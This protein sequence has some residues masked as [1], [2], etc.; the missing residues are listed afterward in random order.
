MTIRRQPSQLLYMMLAYACV[1]VGGIG[2]V[3]PLLPTTPFLLVAAWA[4]T[5][6]SPRLR[7]W[8]YRHPRYGPSIRAWQ[9]HRAIPAGAKLT[10][11]LL[12][13]LS[14][15]TLWVLGIDGRILAGLTLF[16]MA[17]AT[18]ILSR[19]SLPATRTASAPTCRPSP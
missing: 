15:I 5:R 18:F 3:V 19:P 4:A 6:S 13:A 1:G 12:L 9:R 10:A 17:V 2:V 8:L 11:C 14:W 16:F 7:W